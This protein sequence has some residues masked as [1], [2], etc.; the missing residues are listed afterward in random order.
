MNVSRK[1][2]ML[3]MPLRNNRY[4]PLTGLLNTLLQWT[5]QP[6]PVK[7]LKYFRNISQNISWNISRQKI[8][9]NFTSLYN[10]FTAT[11]S[12][13]DKQLLEGRSKSLNRL[14][15]RVLQQATDVNVVK[16]LANDDN[17]NYN[18]NNNGNTISLTTSTSR[19]LTAEPPW[20]TWLLPREKSIAAPDCTGCR[21]WNRPITRAAEFRR[22]FAFGSVT[23]SSTVL[24]STRKTNHA[25][26]NV[27]R[28]KR[29]EQ[30]PSWG[31]W[32]CL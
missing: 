25:A 19:S 27:K 20:T 30:I 6:A 9:W 24:N 22:I 5:I 21:R 31:E 11:R 23:R 17:Y 13:D 29:P 15:F 28:K 12:L 7:F 3:F 4:L 18:D 1:Y 32:V 2:I 26:G 8:S 16:L 14:C 10:H